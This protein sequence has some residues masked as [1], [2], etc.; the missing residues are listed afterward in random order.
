[1]KPYDQ[2]I[3]DAIAELRLEDKPDI[4]AASRRHEVNRSTL[5][6]RFNGEITSRADRYNGQRFLDSAQSGALLAYI[7]DLTVRGLPP[8]VSIHNKEIESGY[9]NAL[10]RNRKKADSAQYYSLY[11]HL[12]GHKIKEYNIQASNSYNMDEKGFLIGF[13]KKMRRI[14]AKTAFDGAKTKHIV[15]D[16]SREWITILA[17]ICADGTALAPSM[18]YQAT[19]GNIQDTWITGYDQKSQIC[20]F[21]SSESGWTNDKLGYEWLTTVYF[22]LEDY[23]SK[24]DGICTVCN[25]LAINTFALMGH[26]QNEA[27]SGRQ[28]YGLLLEVVDQFDLTKGLTGELAGAR[29]QEWKYEN[30]RGECCYCVTERSIAVIIIVQPTNQEKSIPAPL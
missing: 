29:S 21:S 16:G 18:I 5:S 24:E 13:L 20:F 7:K 2:R 28:P 26:V 30:E 10:D 3:E 8:T 11:F 23:Y 12:I 19:T 4:S 17:A 27:A 6:C 9:L 22:F 14:Y 15:Q 25:N 1:M